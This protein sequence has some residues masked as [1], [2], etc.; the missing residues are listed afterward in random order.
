M[1][2]VAP[3]RGD[4]GDLAS[5]RGS[6]GVGQLVV[7]ESE[8]EQQPEARA[9]VG[10]VQPGHVGLDQAH[11]D[12]GVAGAVAGAPQRLGHG[13]DAGDLP[14]RRASVTA[15]DAAAAAE[16]ERGRR[17]A[18]CGLVLRARPERKSAG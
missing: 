3:R 10:G 5:H 16:V 14:P 7:E 4:G 1:T 12:V 17:R 6:L 8:V 11:V 9:D 18:A 13:V 2:R 15:P